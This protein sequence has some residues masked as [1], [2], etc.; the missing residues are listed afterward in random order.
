MLSLLYFDVGDFVSPPDHPSHRLPGE[1]ARIMTKLRFDAVLIPALSLRSSAGF[2]GISIRTNR[3]PV[4]G[5]DLGV[6]GS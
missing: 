5:C 1:F 2:C 3:L 6:R 4:S